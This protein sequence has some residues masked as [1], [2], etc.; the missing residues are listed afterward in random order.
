MIK[1]GTDIT[2]E[3][4]NTVQRSQTQ[5][6]GLATTQQG[7]VANLSPMRSQPS[8]FAVIT[9]VRQVKRDKYDKDPLNVYEWTEVFSGNGS[10]G[11]DD[12]EDE[13]L[14]SKIFLEPTDAQSSE[15]DEDEEILYNPAVEIN[16]LLGVTPGTIV[17]IRPDDA[18]MFEKEDDDGEEQRFNITPWVFVH[19]QSVEPFQVIEDTAPMRVVHGGGLGPANV[20]GDDFVRGFFLSDPQKNIEK[21]YPASNTNRLEENGDE[22]V[23]DLVYNGVARQPTTFFKGSKGWAKLIHRAYKTENEDSDADKTI[24]VPQWQIVS[25]NFSTI[26]DVVNP[27]FACTTDENEITVEGEWEIRFPVG[28][29]VRL[30]RTT[31]KEEDNDYMVV[32][33]AN[34]GADTLI[35]IVGDAGTENAFVG[36]VIKT[37]ETGVVDLWWLDE[38]KQRFKQKV[39][40]QLDTTT[41][42]IDSGFDLLVMNSTL[43]DIDPSSDISGSDTVRLFQHQVWFDRQEYMWHFHQ[44]PRPGNGITLYTIGTQPELFDAGATANIDFNTKMSQ[45][46]HDLAEVDDDIKNEGIYDVVG[47]ISWTITAQRII[48]LDNSD[49]QAQLDVKLLKGDRAV[50]RSALGD[51]VVGTLGKITSSRARGAGAV[52]Q[53]DRAVNSTSGSVLQTLSPGDHFSVEIKMILDAGN[54]GWTTVEEACHITFIESVRAETW[55]ETPTDPLPDPPE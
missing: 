24:W 10:K 21:F 30:T 44:A 51:E 28:S 41:D 34:D 48:E 16:G 32:S 40:E 19:Q 49:V 47:V 27:W 38:T 22:A 23:E 8:L 39:D 33:A 42:L 50:L 26:Y 13:H 18:Y 14:N 20:A 2:A 54:E 25:S 37:D 6:I 45:Y 53:G 46:G 9:G 43:Q 35:K 1:H 31:D 55:F 12:D 36:R 4:L 15:W 7:A 11:D 29:T 5:S 17:Q 3:L 52:G